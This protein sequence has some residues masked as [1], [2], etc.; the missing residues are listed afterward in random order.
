MWLKR[1]DEV[2]GYIKGANASC[3]LTDIGEEEGY[4]RTYKES[5]RCEGSSGA[6]TGFS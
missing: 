1:T 4:R 5:F 2:Y 3:F 6:A